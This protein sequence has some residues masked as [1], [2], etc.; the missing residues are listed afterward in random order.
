MDRQEELKLTT[1]RTREERI[2]G[3]ARGLGQ[4][5]VD[6]SGGVMAVAP[7]SGASRRPAARAEDTQGAEHAVSRL[8]CIRRASLQRCRLVK[9]F[10]L[11]VIVRGRPRGGGYILRSVRRRACMPSRPSVARRTPRRSASV[12]PSAIALRI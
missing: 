10:H 4:L 7:E 1:G 3:E 9:D 12:S 5:R 2:S 6:S 11:R 8:A